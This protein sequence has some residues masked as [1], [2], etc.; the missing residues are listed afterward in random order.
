[1]NVGDETMNKNNTKPSE[2]AEKLEGS[3]KTLYVIAAEC[4]AGC[5]SWFEEGLDKLAA[6]LYAKEG[7]ATDK[8]VE[9]AT[10]LLTEMTQFKQH[11]AAAKT[12]LKEL[13][14]EEYNLPKRGWYNEIKEDVRD[15]KM[16]PSFPYYT[17]FGIYYRTFP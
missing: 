11:A 3:L 4:E 17:R 6:K 14:T 7:T 16:K 10:R 2:T 8:D 15:R 13:K 12:V 1:M 9:I 5:P